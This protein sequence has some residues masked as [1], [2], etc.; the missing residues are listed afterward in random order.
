MVG[1]ID[2][3]LRGLNPSKFGRGANLDSNG[4]NKCSRI[5]EGN[6]INIGVTAP[7][8]TLALGLMYIKSNNEAIAQRVAIPDTHFLLDYIR[9]DFLMLREICSNLIMWDNIEANEEWFH[10]QI[11]NVI[12]ESMEIILNNTSANINNNSNNNRNDNNKN[13]KNHNFDVMG[14]KQ[15]HAYVL[16]GACF[17]LGLKYAGTAHK[18]ANEILTKKVRYFKFLREKVNHKHRPDRCTLE[19][20]LGCCTLALAMVMAGTGELNTLRLFREL[21][22][23]PVEEDIKYGNHMAI[24]MAIG[25]LFLSGGHATLGRSNESI[26]ALLCSLY[27]RF[28]INSEDNQYHLQPLRHLYVSKAL[29]I[30]IFTHTHTLIIIMFLHMTLTN[31]IVFFS[32]NFTH[33]SNRYLR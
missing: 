26:A 2:P 33:F 1:G 12:H 16:A 3:K 9:P 30:Y 22:A 18:G 7:G 32:L 25:L 14:I 6:S 10:R 27:P 19:M 28:P 11:P 4:E 24:G 21:R 5:Y 23:A 17:S 20:C 15:A 13:N 29:Y 8:A 31:H